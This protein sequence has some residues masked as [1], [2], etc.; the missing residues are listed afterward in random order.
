MLGFDDTNVIC[1]FFMFR[2]FSQDNTST[3]HPCRYYI[4][5]LHCIYKTYYGVKWIDG[6]IVKKMNATGCGGGLNSY[7]WTVRPFTVSHTSLMLRYA[8]FRLSYNIVCI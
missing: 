5:I 4:Y 2:F 6:S 7:M 3:K 8:S 1:N